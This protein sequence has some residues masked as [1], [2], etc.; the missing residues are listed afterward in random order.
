MSFLFSFKFA[1][2]IL[3][4]PIVKYGSGGAL[5]GVAT[6]FRFNESGDSLILD[7][8][9]EVD[10]EKDP[11]APYYDG[12]ERLTDEEFDARYVKIDLSNLI[13]TYIG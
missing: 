10:Y 11:D 6:I 12:E 4:Y 7:R 3:R 2:L 1:Q 5:Y 13:W 9:Y 8:E